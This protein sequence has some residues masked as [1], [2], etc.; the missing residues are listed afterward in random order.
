V[1]IGVLQAAQRMLR[2]YGAGAEEECESRASY[3]DMQG[4][5]SVAEGW[6]RT[7]EVIQRLRSGEKPPTA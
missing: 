6:R 7:R 5:K 3:H 1:E 4:D 2:E